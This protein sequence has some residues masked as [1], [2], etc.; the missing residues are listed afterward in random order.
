METQKKNPQR[1]RTRF[2]KAFKL[3][4]IRERTGEQL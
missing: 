1:Q 3:E 4:A 2:S